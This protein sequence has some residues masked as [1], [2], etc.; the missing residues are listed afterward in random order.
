LKFFIKTIF[1]DKKLIKNKNIYFRKALK[2]KIKKTFKQI[3]HNKVE[4]EQKSFQYPLA[5]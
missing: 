1:L 5:L 4:E 2:E 3:P